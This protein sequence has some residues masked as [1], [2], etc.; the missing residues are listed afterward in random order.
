MREIAG[1]TDRAAAP[2]LR[3]R[4]YARVERVT[5][6]ETTDPRFMALMRSRRAP[7]AGGLARHVG[8]ARAPRA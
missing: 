2:D 4:E 1:E 7:D 5:A 3:A 6:A 8:F